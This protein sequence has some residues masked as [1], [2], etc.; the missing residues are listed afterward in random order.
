M[1]SL[2]LSES[3]LKTLPSIQ[4]SWHWD[5]R[6]SNS[7]VISRLPYEMNEMDILIMFSQY[8]PIAHVKLLRDKITGKSLGTAFLR[9]ERW[10]STVLAID[11]F[12]KVGPKG[13]LKIDHCK[14]K[15]VRY[16]DKVAGGDANREW[17][18]EVEK[19]LQ[20][21]FAKEGEDLK[22]IEDSKGEDDLLDPMADYITKR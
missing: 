7:I 10:E 19:V 13:G 4:S 18:E 15:G 12:N 8:G 5:Y 16:D 9:Y 6:D 11:N 20:A 21:Q 1:T 2:K 3:E 17:D 14:F 22:A